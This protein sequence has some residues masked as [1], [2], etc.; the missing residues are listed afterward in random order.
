MS[1][2]T[3]LTVALIAT[4]AAQLHEGRQALEAGRT[5]EAVTSLTAV[6]EQSAH[7]PELGWA[8][9][10]YRAQARRAA[11]QPAAAFED[12]RWLATRALP[13]A[14][15]EPARTAFL[16]AGGQSQDLVPRAPP[17]EEWRRVQ[18]WIAAGQPLRVFEA[19]TDEFAEQV[20]TMMAVLGEQEPDVLGEW[21]AEEDAMLIGQRTDEAAGT[22]E[23]VFRQDEMVCTVRWEQ[24]GTAWKISGLNIRV[25]DGD[26]PLAGPVAPPVEAPAAVPEEL[27]ELVRQLGAD[28]PAVRARARA[29]L[30]ALGP[31]AAAALRSFRSHPDPEVAETIRELLENR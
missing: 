29:K 31:D 14:I 28:D 3:N 27:A 24:V 26:V 11:H 25:S 1:A 9:R 10:W 7:V 20:R 22:A 5:A 18:Q 2:V 16:A 17:L 21:L 6:I 12:L 13:P 19:L 4:L 8:A 15:R 23:L 30:R